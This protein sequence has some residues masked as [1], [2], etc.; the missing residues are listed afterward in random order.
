MRPQS[1]S[2]VERRHSEPSGSSGQ[3]SALFAAYSGRP[4]SGAFFATRL[5]RDLREQNGLVYYVGATFEAGD[6]VALLGPCRQHDDRQ[7]A[8]FPIALEC[9]RELQSAGVRQHPVDQQKIREFVG[10]LGAP[11]ARIGG[12]ADFKSRTT[13][14]ESDHF[15]D[16]PLVLDD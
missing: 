8:G 6:L 10:Y 16:R 12:F 11:A 5:F 13:Q 14:A 2:V 3:G 7:L 15:A 1:G 4:L 9:A